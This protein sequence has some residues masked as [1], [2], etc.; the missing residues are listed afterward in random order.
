MVTSST[1]GVPVE[2]AVLTIEIA[3]PFSAKLTSFSSFHRRKLLDFIASIKV[4]AVWMA[5]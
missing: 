4:L 3:G 1:R 2:S 5:R